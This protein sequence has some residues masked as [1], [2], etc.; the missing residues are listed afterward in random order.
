MRVT[1]ILFICCSLNF[2]LNE[3][4]FMVEFFRGDYDNGNGSG[5]PRVAQGANYHQVEGTKVGM[6]NQSQSELSKYR[7]V[8]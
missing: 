7:S 4:F 5:D 2:V 3:M 6:L 8:F 1:E